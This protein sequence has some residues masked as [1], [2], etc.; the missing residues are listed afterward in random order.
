VEMGCD[1]RVHAAR[2][3]PVPQDPS[4]TALIV[5]DWYWPGPYGRAPKKEDET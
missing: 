1:A 5:S 2:S 3:A 4:F